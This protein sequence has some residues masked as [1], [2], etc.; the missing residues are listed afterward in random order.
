M[1]FGN[2]SWVCSVTLILLVSVWFVEWPWT[3][4]RVMDAMSG[5]GSTIYP[6]A[7][8]KSTGT[9]SET[10]VP[11]EGVLSDQMFR[12]HLQ[13]LPIVTQLQARHASKVISSLN[14]FRRK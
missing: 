3:E 7:T 12:M 14:R 6:E 11:V 9:Q 10:V 13:V 5:E 2:V 4:S 8:T 1:L